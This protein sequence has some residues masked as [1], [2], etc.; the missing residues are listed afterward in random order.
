MGTSH[1]SIFF[2][3][4]K[5]IS[6]RSGPMEVPTYKSA[7]VRSKTYLYDFSETTDF[8][9]VKTPM[10]IKRFDIHFERF[11]DNNSLNSSPPKCRPPPFWLRVKK[12]SGSQSCFYEPEIRKASRHWV[13]GHRYARILWMSKPLW[14][15][16]HLKSDFYS[17]KN[18][19]KSI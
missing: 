1:D 11:F 7:S 10:G 5:K 14:V 9:L 3:T 8:F 17:E 19:L 16:S 13:S 15:W 4:Q 6:Y 12:K 2:Y 18:L